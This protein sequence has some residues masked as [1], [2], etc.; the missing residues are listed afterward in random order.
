MDLTEQQVIQATA[1]GRLGRDPEIKTTNSGKE[2]ASF[3]IASNNRNGDATW[4]RVTVWRQQLVEFVT[5]NA[6]KG[7]RVMVAGGLEIR[8]WGDE[9]EQ[10]ALEMD[11]HTLELYDWPDREVEAIDKR[12]SDEIGAALKETYAPRRQTKVRQA[13]AKA[14]QAKKELNTQRAKAPRD[15]EELPF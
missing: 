10:Q 15:A 1:T 11:C 2:F 9:A 3:N 4:L 8:K 7:A 13:Q 12:H 6:R 5:K 14:E